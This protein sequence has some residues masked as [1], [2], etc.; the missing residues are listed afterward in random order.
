MSSRVRMTSPKKTHKNILP[1]LPTNNLFDLRGLQKKIRIAIAEDHAILREALAVML[2]SQPD[3]QVEAKACNGREVLQALRDNPADVLILDLMMPECDGFEVL[4]VMSQQRY[5]VPILVLTGSEDKSVYAQ[6][7][8]LGGRGLV[9]KTEGAEKL[10]SAVRSV[11]QGKLAFCNDIAQQVLGAIA[12]KPGICGALSR[13]SAREQ[14]IA[15]LVARGMKNSEIARELAISYNT[16]KVHLQTIFSKTGVRDRLE[17]MT[18][19]LSTRQL[20][21]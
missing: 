15:S 3:F 10:C 7:V 20:T 9:V 14:E 2:N 19:A 21:A 5:E 18:L 11:A 6:V 12:P 17:L 16:V 13:L 4:R 1:T 8:K